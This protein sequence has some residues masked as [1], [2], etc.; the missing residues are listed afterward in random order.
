MSDVNLADVDVGKTVEEDVS[1]KLFL[2]SSDTDDYISS[3]E[4]STQTRENNSKNLS[5]HEML[6]GPLH[7]SCMETKPV[8]NGV[9]DPFGKPYSENG[10]VSE[11]MDTEVHKEG[12]DLENAGFDTSV[13][14]EE[15]DATC[16]GYISDGSS[17]GADL[18]CS[19]NSHGSTDKQCNGK[20]DKDLKPDIRDAVH[21]ES[22]QNTCVK[23]GNSEMNTDTKEQKS[24]IYSCGSCGKQLSSKSAL[25]KHR[26]SQRA[27]ASTINDELS[28][29]QD[30]VM[31]PPVKQHRLDEEDHFGFEE[32]QS[33]PQLVG[34]SLTDSPDQAQL[35]HQITSYQ[36]SLDHQGSETAEHDKHQCINP[37]KCDCCDRVFPDKNYLISHIRSDHQGQ[38]NILCSYCDTIISNADDL[39]E[40]LKSN[41]TN[42]Q[43]LQNKT[44]DPN[45]L[46][47]HKKI[48]AEKQKANSR[49]MDGSVTKY[50]NGDDYLE[51]GI[52]FTCKLNQSESPRARK[53]S[54]S[55]DSVSSDSPLE[56]EAKLK[57][58]LRKTSKLPRS[59]SADSITQRFNSLPS[60]GLYNGV[61]DRA[62]HTITPL[63]PYDTSDH[64]DDLD[65]AVTLNTPEG[66]MYQCKVCGYQT[67]IKQSMFKHSVSHRGKKHCCRFCDITF[68][69]SYS[70]QHHY[71]TN[72]GEETFVSRGH[73]FVHN[74]HL[75]DPVQ[76]KQRPQSV[77]SN[78]KDSPFQPESHS[79]H[80]LTHES[81]PGSSEG[82]YICEWC[83]KSYEKYQLYLDHCMTF[84]ASRKSYE[85]SKCH[86]K[87]SW[88]NSLNQHTKLCMS[89]ESEI[90]RCDQCPSEFKRKRDL[91][92]HVEGKHG[93]TEK[94]HTCS[95]GKTYKWQSGL[96]RHRSKSGC[97]FMVHPNKFR[98][99]TALD[100]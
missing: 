17:S 14:Y 73:N 32:D 99:K 75:D 71:C 100:I 7:L 33:G 91:K 89:S 59:S 47:S 20:E 2:V 60:Q 9:R 4:E 69:D 16:S 81:R 79:S 34:S 57:E 65:Q 77:L 94:L 40:H 74:I 82:T 22:S 39:A 83:G 1:D 78:G 93:E 10:S 19:L 3:D 63:I 48:Y 11:Y 58:D 24:N 56:R 61:T 30:E 62:S 72:H 29:D 88:R 95:C 45:E 28:D 21:V 66:V 97:F 31:G 92:V 13:C 37:D 6:S 85:C 53:S 36:S 52:D 51:N 27:Y 68:T 41:H 15:F 35:D 55:K 76:H 96:A 50:T 25:R 43:Q 90:Y 42:Q 54:S 98:T 5:S 87:F 86:A 46:Q 18:Q 70:L 38:S 84:H 8:C 44:P 64:G 80:S 26:C 12:R 23:G 67:R 49:Q